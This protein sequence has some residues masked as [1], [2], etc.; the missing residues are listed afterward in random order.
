MES[1]GRFRGSP[2]SG[3]CKAASSGNLTPRK[4]CRVNEHKAVDY[5]LQRS[6]CVFSRISNMHMIFM[7]NFAS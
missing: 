2:A 7:C 5:F 3:K 4:C 6:K 1:T